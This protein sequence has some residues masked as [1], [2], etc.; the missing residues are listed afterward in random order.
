M[1]NDGALLPAE[2]LACWRGADARRCAAGE[3]VER[4]IA[5]LEWQRARMVVSGGR[6][7]RL[8]IAMGFYEVDVIVRCAVAQLDAGPLET[9]TLD[10]HDFWSDFYA[11]TS[12]APVDVLQR[13]SARLAGLDWPGV[14]SSANLLHAELARRLFEMGREGEAMAVLARV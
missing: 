2:A 7:P 11:I 12:L 8:M 5:W 10:D 4:V 9:N 3:P 6:M 13:L 14:W 1:M